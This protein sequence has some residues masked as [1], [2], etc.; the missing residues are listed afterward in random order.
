MAKKRDITSFYKPGDP[1]S[2]KLLRDVMTEGEVPYTTAYFWLCGKRRPLPL[3]QNMICRL[4]ATHFDVEL[5]REELFPP[6][7]R[8]NKRT[9]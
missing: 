9:I 8:R 7:R 5:T 6:K 3:Y 4:V 2:A 1:S